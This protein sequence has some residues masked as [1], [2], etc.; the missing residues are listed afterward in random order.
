MPAWR[1]HLDPDGYGYGWL[2]VLI[3]CSGSRFGLG[4]PE[5][6]WAPV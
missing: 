6:D 4:A 2:L 3:L 5:E 1:R